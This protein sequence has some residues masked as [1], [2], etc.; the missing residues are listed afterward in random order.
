MIKNLCRSGNYLL[1]VYKYL[2]VFLVLLHCGACSFIMPS[3]QDS[4]EQYYGEW[5]DLYG[6]AQE[7]AQRQESTELAIEK[8]EKAI[9]IVERRFPENSN[10]YQLSMVSSLRLL[11]RLLEQENNFDEASKVYSRAVSEAEKVFG[12]IHV[13]LS[14]ALRDLG[15]VYVKQGNLEPAQTCFD[16]SLEINLRLFGNSHLFVVEDYL[17]LAEVHYGLGR[18]Q[19]ASLL[20]LKA[21]F[22]L[23]VNKEYPAGEMGRLFLL[24]AQI[25]AQ[26]GE[27]D[28]AENLFKGS[29]M[30]FLNEA[31]NKQAVATVERAVK[32]W[33]DDSGNQRRYDTFQVWLK[34]QAGTSSSSKDRRLEVSQLIESYYLSWKMLEKYRALQH[35]GLEGLLRAF[36]AYF[37]DLAIAYQREANWER[38]ET[39][40]KEAQEFR[41]R[42]QSLLG[43]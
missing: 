3:Q 37:Q 5:Q 19:Q 40:L 13:A 29:A 15:I 42:A 24:Q 34:E 23:A 33:S 2:L 6:E 28:F 35:G 26:A 38:M 10:K 20:G 17:W 9:S 18:P 31:N 27:N 30:I 36:S 7:L 12:P 32:K 22:N 11:G 39:C 16:R 4:M 8:I 41:S 25:L 1:R 14:E 21:L 43:G